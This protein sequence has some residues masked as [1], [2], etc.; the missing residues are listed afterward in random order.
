M[1]TTIV[2]NLEECGKPTET[3]CFAD[4]TQLLILPYGG[5]MLGLF[6]PGDDCN[7][8]WTQPAL[9]SS[10]T[11]RAY[12]ERDAWHN[13]GGERIW[14]NPEVHLFFP[15]PGDRSIYVQ[16]RGFDPGNYVAKTTTD[17]LQLV[18]RG[19]IRH[20]GSGH[21]TEIEI[22]RRFSPAAN[23]LRTVIELMDGVKYAGYTQRTSVTLPNGS[24]D[25]FGLWNLL[26]LPYGGDLLVATH[27]QTSPKVYFGDIPDGD[28]VSSEN[29]IRYHMRAQRIAKIGVRAEVTTGR[30]AYLSGN[31]GEWS[32]VIRNLFVNP[33][34][35]YIDVPPD[36]FA[37]FGYAIQACCVYHR[38][39]G[40]FCELEYHA[41]AIGGT[42]GETHCLDE[43]QVWA[44]RGTRDAVLR[45]ARI[46][47]TPEA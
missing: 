15:A 18:N 42:G 47:I 37:D 36:N 33:S 8:L 30:A 38:E 2:K 46:L 20:F 26:Q 22:V 16:P 29:L 14:L 25:S 10:G 35:D 6:A 39:L 34:G 13:S 44:F 19:T 24:S 31:A 7:F 17:G 40:Q 28:L 43:S 27:S 12:Y 3:L 4:G 21:D 9:L 32:L 5:R 1:D 23:P 11:A 41:P 45:I